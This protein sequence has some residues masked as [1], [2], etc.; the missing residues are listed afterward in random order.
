M[1]IWSACYVHS[2]PKCLAAVYEIKCLHMYV[3]E[4][5]NERGRFATPTCFAIFDSY[6]IWGA[7]DLNL[8][9]IYSLASKG[10][11]KLGDL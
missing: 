1:R 7:C 9:M 10:D 6:D 5:G 2:R 3:P 11:F 4:G 8:V